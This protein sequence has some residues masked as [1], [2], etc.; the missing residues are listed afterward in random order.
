MM[1]GLSLPAFTLV[2]IAISLIGLAA[3]FGVMHGFMMARDSPSWTK[4]FLVFTILTSLTGFLFPFDRVL[5][6]HIVGAVSLVVLAIAVAALYVYHLA[7]AWRWIYVASAVAALYLNAFVLAFQTFVKN[8]AL[9]ELAPTQS[10]PPFVVA[11]ALLFVGFV[12]MGVLAA[13]RFR[14]ATEAAVRLQPL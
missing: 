2:H 4:V 3:G 6:S 1:L 8:P 7:G 12:V 10:E 9:K 13:R 11:Q 14:P 5:P